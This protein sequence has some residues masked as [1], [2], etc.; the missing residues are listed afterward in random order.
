LLFERVAVIGV[1]LI[2]GSLALA[3]RRA[4]LIGE[5]IG[6]GRSAANLEDA[7]DRGI[8][9]RTTSDLAE[10]GPVDLAVIAV[11]VRTSAAIARDL[12]PHLRPGTVVTDVGSVKQWVI[13]AAAAALPATCP[14]VGAHPIAGS[15]QTGARAARVDLFEDS[16]CVVTPVPET[17]PAARDAVVELWQGVGARVREMTPA[18]HDRALAWTSHLGHV[19]SYSLARAVG[20]ADGGDIL[21]LAGPSLR[22]LTRLAGGSAPMWRDIFLT[23]DRA[24]LA[25]A[26]AF[27]AAL[28]ELRAAIESGD[29]A[30]VDALLDL[31]LATRRRL[32][33]HGGES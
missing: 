14:F 18:E 30:T 32:E 10:I 29:E 25:A 7:R 20:A 33:G 27:A 4:G 31:G 15:E 24:V 12:A 3:G 28:A 5:V 2:G 23:N 19:L 17:P 8:A 26:D 6:V 1:G 16:V 11:P 21:A 13:D 22:E 9:D